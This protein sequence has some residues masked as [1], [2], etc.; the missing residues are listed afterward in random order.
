GQVLSGQPLDVRAALRPPLFA[1]EG[2]LVLD[3][4]ELFKRRGETMAIVIDEYGSVE[5]LVTQDDILEVIVGALPSSEVI[6]EPRA[7]QREDGSWLLD[8][9]L[10]IDTLKEILDIEL[11]PAEKQ[12]RYQTVGGFML[13]QLGSIPEAGAHFE[14][15]QYRFEVLDMDGNRIDKVLLTFVV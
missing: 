15:G 5:G 3:L 6:D 2:T 7:V 10:Y 13:A 9:M 12:A 4:L 14:W 1:P 11:L 8:G